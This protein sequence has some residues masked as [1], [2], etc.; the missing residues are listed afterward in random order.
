MRVTNNMLVMNF[1]SDYNSNL[2]RLQKDQNMLSTGKKVSKPSDDPVAVANILKIKTEIARNDAYTKN[3]DD[4]KSWLSLTDTALGQ[5]GDLLQNARELAVQGSNGTMTQS[6]MQSIAAQVD[7]IKQQLI[8]VGNTQYNG[9]YIFA[10][11]KTDTKPFSDGSNGYA[12]DDGV[13]QFEIG[14][15]GNTLQVNVTGDKVFDVTSG[16]SKLLNVMD[17]L[18]NALKSGDNQTVSNIIGDIDNQLQ[19]VLAIR[20]DAGAKAN[21]I[22]LTANRLSDDNYNFTALLSKNQDA[23]I[24]QVITN[25]KMDDNVYRASLAAGAMIIQPSLVDFLR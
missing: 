10:G 6:D 24:A 2:E 19:N 15:G 25:L 4:A 7:Q 13:I 11:Y 23:D 20:A 3:T 9:R 8:Q 17:N 5:I 18:S 22:D 1:M 21:R 14:A 16:T 12:G